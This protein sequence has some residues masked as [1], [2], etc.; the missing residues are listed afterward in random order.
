MLVANGFSRRRS[1]QQLTT[2]HTHVLHK[3]LQ[4]EE[5]TAP[6][7]PAFIHDKQHHTRHARGSRPSI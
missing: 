3:Q 4:S 7:S 5:L 2:G 1:R 6:L